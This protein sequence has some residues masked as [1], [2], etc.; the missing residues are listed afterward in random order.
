MDLRL[1]FDCGYV[2]TSSRKSAYIR[3]AAAGRASLG[4]LAGLSLI[5]SS[6]AIEDTGEVGKVSAGL[7]F[8]DSSVPSGR[9]RLP[10]F[11]FLSMAGQM[12]R[13]SAGQARGKERT[14][15]FSKF[16]FLLWKASG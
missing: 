11:F 2:S 5:P 16:I 9:A 12:D 7:A 8:S 14:N 6:P 13:S 15:L 1:V 4:F 10:L 3:T